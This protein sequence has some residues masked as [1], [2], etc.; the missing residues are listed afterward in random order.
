MIFLICLGACLEGI[1]VIGAVNAFCHPECINS[2]SCLVLD[3]VLWRPSRG[4]VLLARKL[5][6]LCG[7]TQLITLKLIGSR[8]SDKTPY[9][10]KVVKGLEWVVSVLL[11]GF[12]PILRFSIRVQRYSL[13]GY[14]LHNS[15]KIFVTSFP[16]PFYDPWRL[17]WIPKELERKYICCSSMGYLP[18]TVYT[19]MSCSSL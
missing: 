8:T 14:S 13:Q 19:L 1:E 4:S 15:V 6:S 7:E 3:K 9:I 16:L 12:S 18:Q 17:L 10:Y 2:V 11:S 5:L